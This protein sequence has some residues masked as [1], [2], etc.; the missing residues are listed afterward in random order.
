MSYTEKT[1]LALKIIDTHTEDETW[2][3]YTNW[4]IDTIDTAAKTRAD[5][6]N[7]MEPSRINLSDDL[8]TL[9]GN[10]DADDTTLDGYED[11]ID[12]IVAEGS[13][14]YDFTD[15]N[16]AIDDIEAEAVTLQASL[17]AIGLGGG[18]TGTF[19]YSSTNYDQTIVI[20]DGLIKSFTSV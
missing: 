7:N 20:E 13:Y 2:G 19:E 1:Y 5:G 11:R 15:I 9:D 12:D 18:Y 4:N 8:T 6:V 16:A 17:D 14:A 10:L 3:A